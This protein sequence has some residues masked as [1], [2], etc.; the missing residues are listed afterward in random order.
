MS[1]HMSDH[2]IW[3][4]IER[5]DQTAPHRAHLARVIRNLAEWTDYNSDGWA[6]YAAPRRSAQKAI[7]AIA[8][9]TWEANQAQERIDLT[10]PELRRALAPIK[11][12][13]T[14]MIGKGIMTPA[15]R[16][17]ILRG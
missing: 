10:E 3:F 4:A 11:A 5:F 7:A 9:T 6:Y 2:E 13:C 15:D 12:Y 8:S 17:N 16:D 1:I 14:R